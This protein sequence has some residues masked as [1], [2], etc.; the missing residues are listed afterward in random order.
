MTELA[1]SYE[2]FAIRHTRRGRPNEPRRSPYNAML[3]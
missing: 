3:K 1:S 2:L